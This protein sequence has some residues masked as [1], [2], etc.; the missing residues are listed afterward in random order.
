MIGGGC[1]LLRAPQWNVQSVVGMNTLQLVT[2]DEMAELAKVSRV[3]LWKYRKLGAPHLK[4]G[5]SIRWQP[6]L[7]VQWMK[8]NALCQRTTQHDAA[9]GRDRQ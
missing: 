9:D 4:I 3:T 7:F 1:A 2:T 8:D 6:D 5:K